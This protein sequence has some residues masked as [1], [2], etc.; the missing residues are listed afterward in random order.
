MPNPDAVTYWDCI[1]V[2]RRLSNEWDGTDDEQYRKI[3][4]LHD[5]TMILFDKSWGEVLCDSIR[6]FR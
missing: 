1:R 3:A 4:A 5:A 2:L 6:E